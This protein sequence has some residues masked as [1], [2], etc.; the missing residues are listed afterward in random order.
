MCAVEIAQWTQALHDQGVTW[1]YEGSDNSGLVDSMLE[2][3][4]PHASWG[5]AIEACGRIQ[6][7][8]HFREAA[9]ALVSAGYGGDIGDM[10]LTEPE[11]LL[12]GRRNTLLS[13]WVNLAPVAY[14]TRRFMELS[15]AA[16][17]IAVLRSAAFVVDG[18]IQWPQLEMNGTAWWAE[19][20][21]RAERERTAELVTTPVFHLA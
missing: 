4:Y 21:R 1:T 11:R 8:Y 10:P 5:P 18:V 20:V 9:E 7:V 17:K 6:Q 14:L 3:N 13:F 15:V 12:E 16:A 2:A 19:D